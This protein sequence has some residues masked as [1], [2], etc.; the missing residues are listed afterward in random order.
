[1]TSQALLRGVAGR[2]WVAH[3][4]PHI[5]SIC[6]CAT[7]HVI[8]CH[9]SMVLVGLLS[10]RKSCEVRAL[11]VV[12]ESHFLLGHGPSPRGRR[13]MPEFFQTVAPRT[14]WFYL[15]ANEEEGSNTVLH[16]F[17]A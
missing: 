8:P 12:M 15:C 2:S 11:G 10:L 3:D 1:M 16:K 7:P 4:S 13:E 5:V 6:V 17:G 14:Q 9:L